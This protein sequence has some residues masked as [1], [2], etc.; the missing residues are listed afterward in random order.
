MATQA[1]LKKERALLAGFGID[2]EKTRTPKKRF[3]RIYENKESP[4]HPLQQN[5]PD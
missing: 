2:V 5:P 3:I 1:E 4:Y